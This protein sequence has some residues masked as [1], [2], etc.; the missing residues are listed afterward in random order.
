MND[1]QEGGLD[2]R[3]FTIGKIMK[4]IMLAAAAVTSIFPLIWVFYNSFKT[5]TELFTEPWALPGKLHFENYIFA[6]K[7]AN[8]GQYFF[9]SVI[10]CVTAMF[11]CLLLS[12]TAAF[13]LT[14]LR[15]KLS[16]AAMMVFV[17]GM[18]IPI[19]ST[20]IPMFL[21]FSKIKITNT[22]WALI[23]PYTTNGMPISI[24]ILTGFLKAF[25]AEI[26]ES[27]IIDGASMRKLFFK[28]TL[29]LT[30]PSIATVAI[31]TFISM[32]NELSYAMV[33]LS[34]KSK[35]T[36]PIGLN[37]FKGEYSTNYVP[38]FAAVVITVVPSV[39]IFTLFNRQVMEGMTAGAVKG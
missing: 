2:M 21:M 27:A 39:L 13:A 14:R 34:D 30:K 35:M 1:R 17:V 10:V 31:Y 22:L 18:M 19:H 16:G 3:R 29:P 20:L 26:E 11:F 36:L 24:F 23:I 6:W 12:T 9:N 4:W 25:P 7:Q 28:V 15:W 8:I 32:W 38:L 37:S 5:N 33:F